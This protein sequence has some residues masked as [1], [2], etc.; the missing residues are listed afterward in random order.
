MG[1]VTAHRKSSGF[2]FNSCVQ[3]R[4]NSRSYNEIFWCDLYRAIAHIDCFS[5]IPIAQELPSTIKPFRILVG[6]IAA[7]M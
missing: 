6:R 7:A 1:V 3:S 2:D 4:N 5:G